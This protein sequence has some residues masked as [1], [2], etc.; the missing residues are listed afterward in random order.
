MTLA[1]GTRLGPYQIVAPAGSGGMGDVYRARDVRLERDVAVKTLKGPFTERFEREA[2][3]IS[4]LNHPNICTLYDVGQHEGSGYLVMEFIEGEPVHGPLPVEQAVAYGIQICEALHAAHRKG[5]VHRDLKPANILVTK[6]GIKLLDFGLA[7]L[8]AS[9]GS[10]AGVNASSAAERATVA[11]LT[12]A[13][14]VVGTPQYMAPEQIEGREV[15][16]RTD[17]F[18]F[19]CVL[20]ELLTGQRAFKGQTSSSVMAAILATTPTPIEE[21]IPLTPPALERI[22]TR[23]LAKDPEDRWH[24]ARDVAAELQWVAQGGSRVGLPAVVSGRRRVREQVA[25]GGCVLAVLAATGFGAAWKL[26]EPAAPA[27]VRFQLVTPP[28]VHNASPPVVSPDGR[29]IVFAADGEGGRMI[30]IRPLESL[31]ARPLPGTAGVLRPFWSPDSRFVAFMSQGKLKKVD[32]AGGPPQTICDAQY[33]ADGTWSADGV[34]LL[35]GRGN[36]P[37]WRCPAAGGVRQPFVFSPDEPEGMSGAGWPEFLPDGRHFLFTAT[38]GDS[39]EMTLMVGKLDSTEVKTLFKTTTRV[40]YVE[41]GYLL[42]VRERTLVAQKFDAKTL[43]VHGEPLPIGEGLGT[44]NLGLASFSA[45]RNGVLVFRGGELTGTQLTW[46]DRSGKETPMLDA[47][48][49]YRDTSLSL[50]AARLVYGVE[51]TGGKGDLWI[52]D[53]ARG[54]STRFTFDPAADLN[55]QWSP[56]GRRIVYTSRAKGRGDLLIKDASGTREAEPLLVD[57]DEK[58]ISDWSPDGR[59]ILYTRRA[60]AGSSWDVWALP[61]EGDRKPMPIVETPFDELWA[62]FS[63]DGRYI[64][65]QSNESGRAEIYVHEFPEARNKWRVSTDGGIEAFWRADGRELFYRAGTRVMAVPLQAG[66]AFVPGTPIQLFQARFASAVVRGRYRPARDGQ[67]FLV[68]ATLARETEQP[69]AVVLNW[70]AA[71]PR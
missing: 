65:Y 8:A 41:P 6:Q 60:E 43:T 20:Y 64:A 5:I 19:G 44:D 9:T 13:H 52:R 4:A 33:G 27:V 11:A 39:P 22:V 29:H 34:I 69:A 54:V 63:P 49:E 14:T 38:T 61:L 70:T 26:R 32:I 21:L 42:F 50:D 67:R 17:I 24:T 53:L 62:T 47:P 66:G 31:E 55:P 16:A 12:G 58:Y 46:V 71:L 3:A 36:D 40:Q 10:I 59:H 45:S 30:Y 25:W 51:D 23:C 68:L 2:Q 15:D 48:A 18:A 28:G 35:D 56:D 1:S 57:A 37:L 7:K